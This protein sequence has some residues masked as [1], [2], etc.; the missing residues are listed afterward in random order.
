MDTKGLLALDVETTGLDPDLAQIRAA[1][2]AATDGTRVL[3]SDDEPGLLRDL[4]AF[5]AHFPPEI[6]II[7]WNGEEFDLP[8]LDR[9]FHATGIKS[10]LRVMLAAGTGKYGGRLYRGDWGGRRHLDIAPYFK[11]QAASLGVP[12]SLKPLARALLHVQPVEV[13]RSGAAIGRL[14]PDRLASYVASDAEITLGL[15]KRLILTFE[16]A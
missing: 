3:V 6:T 11:E 10:T 13:D 16:P 14:E 12:W 1:A 7:T 2:L 9:R 4:E 15:A 5:V 8:F